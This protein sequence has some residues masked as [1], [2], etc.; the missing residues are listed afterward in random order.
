MKITK[1]D[2][3]M[4]VKRLVGSKETEVVEINGR[5]FALVGWNGERYIHCWETDENTFALDS[6]KEYEIQ[7]IYQ[8]VGEPDEDG[9]YLQYEVIG[10]EIM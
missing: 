4:K 9:D 8:G 7:P 5:W 3:N 2:K 10:Y 6:D 1:G